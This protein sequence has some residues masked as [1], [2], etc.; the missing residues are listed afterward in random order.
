[1]HFFSWAGAWTGEWIG[2]WFTVRQEL[3][4]SRRRVI[5][6]LS[7][8]LPLL[9]WCAVSYVPFIWHPVVHVQNPGEVDYFQEDMLI[10]KALFNEELANMQSQGKLVPQGYAANPI[11]LPAPHEVAKAFYTAFTT[12]PV[13]KDA[14][15]LHQSLWQSIQ[16]IFWGFFISSLISLDRWRGFR[17]SPR[18][19]LAPS[20]R[21]GA[22]SRS[23]AASSV[24]CLRRSG[25]CWGSPR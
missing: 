15:W 23:C 13:Q 5:R 19:R 24:R 6:W 8:L 12:P 16:V 21:S 25:T 11:Y 7:F 2:T 10:E 20:P 22:S 9:I 4:P 3:S 18:F 14:L 1:M 17:C